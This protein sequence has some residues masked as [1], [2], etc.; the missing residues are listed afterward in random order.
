MAWPGADLTVPPWTTQDDW[1][2]QYIGYGHVTFHQSDINPLPTFAAGDTVEM[3]VD[4][5]ATLAWFILNGASIS[6]DPVAG[7]GGFTFNAGTYYPY[8]QVATG[9][10]V[11]TVPGT[12]PA[13]FSPWD[14]SA[15]RTRGGGAPY[16][17]KRNGPSVRKRKK[18]D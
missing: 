9:D 13:G 7:T 1:V 15:T 12:P 18:P 8:A 2:L 16:A 5:D 10:Q 11:T 4:F 14:S 6:G 3:C 17:R